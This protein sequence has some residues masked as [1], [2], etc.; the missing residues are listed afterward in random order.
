MVRTTVAATNQACAGSRSS[1]ARAGG[2]GAAIRIAG[3]VVCPPGGRTRSI[4][5]ARR[6]SP[7]DTKGPAPTGPQRIIL[8][9]GTDDGSRLCRDGFTC[10]VAGPG[11]HQDRADL[12]GFQ[13]FVLQEILGEESNGIDV[14][15]DHLAGAFVAVHYDATDLF[16]DPLCS[17]LADVVRPIRIVGVTRLAERERS[18]LRHAPFAN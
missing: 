7:A 18:E 16:V 12:V 3:I 15:L 8:G 10:L 9:F 6:R 13:R 5:A 1:L 17:G 11:A 4:P 2:R 14:V